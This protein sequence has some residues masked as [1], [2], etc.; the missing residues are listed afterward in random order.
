MGR[1]RRCEA[2]W[3]SLVR[4][5]I[6]SSETGDPKRN[7]EKEKGGRCLSTSIVVVCWSWNGERRAGPGSCLVCVRA[8]CR[9]LSAANWED[10]EVG[11]GLVVGPGDMSTSAHTMIVNNLTVTS[12]NHIRYGVV[13]NM[14]PSHLCE[15]LGISPSSILGFRTC[16][17]LLRIGFL[18]FIC[19]VCTRPRVN[20]VLIKIHFAVSVWQQTSLASGSTTRTSPS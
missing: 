12:I 11:G 8:R 9:R 5:F 14:M 15:R 13:A 10:G 20:R 3:S 18:Q 4:G 2:G 7:P 19:C 1:E 16:S 17:L 6:D